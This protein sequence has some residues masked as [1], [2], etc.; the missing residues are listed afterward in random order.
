VAEACEGFDQATASQDVDTLSRILDD[1]AVFFDF[2]GRTRKKDDI[3]HYNQAM[4]RTGYFTEVQMGEMSVTVVA[5]DTAVLL[6]N[7]TIGTRGRSVKDVEGREITGDYRIF[8][9]FVERPVGWR[10]VTVQMIR[11]P[12]A[13]T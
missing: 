10:L 3:I 4:Q 2:D 1:D 11:T 6:A 7:I 8:H 13:A 9:V 5:P 12:F